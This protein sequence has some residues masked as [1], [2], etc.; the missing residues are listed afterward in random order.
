MESRRQRFVGEYKTYESKRKEA[1]IGDEGSHEDHNTGLSPSLSA[2]RG[3]WSKRLHIT[4]CT[5]DVNGQNVYHSQSLAGAI[6][7]DHNP[8]SN[9]EVELKE[10]TVVGC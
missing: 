6:G 10:L 5:P 2:P 1:G 9:T 8:I 3:L 4:G 7:E